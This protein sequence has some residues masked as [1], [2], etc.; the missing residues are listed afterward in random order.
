MK[1]QSLLVRYPIGMFEYGKEYSNLDTLRH[2]REIADLPKKLK[3]IVKKLREGALDKTYRQHGW[4]VRQVVHH[5]ADSHINAYVRMKLAVTENAPIVKPYEEQLWAETEDGKHGSAGMSL[6]LLSALHKRW[7]F[8]LSHLSDEDL[9]KV[10]YNPSSKRTIQLREAIALYAWHGKHHLAHVKLVA[11]GNKKHEA[12]DTDVVEV[13]AKRSP[14]LPK[15]KAVAGQT[16]KESSGEKEAPKRRGRP[17]MSKS[18][19]SPVKQ[20]GN[21]RAV[22][23]DEKVQDLT[24]TAADDIAASKDVVTSTPTAAAAKPKR[25]R[26]AVGKVASVTTLEEKPKMSVEERMAK[27][28]AGRQKSAAAKPVSEEVVVSSEK[29]KRGRPAV[30]KVAPEATAPEKP[31]RSRR[32]PEEIAAAKEKK[33]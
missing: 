32:T 29:P 12:G 15:A 3:K 25:G 27:A 7:V 16:G 10:Y 26:P 8:F 11:D 17:P 31:K 9:D 21:K 23:A 13:K 28:R 22:A 33:G 4:T 20:P 5:L 19:A 30:N 24:R 2:I 6:K 1:D 14:K 18:S